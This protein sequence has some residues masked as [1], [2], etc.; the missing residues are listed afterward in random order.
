MSRIAK[1]IEEFCPDGVEFK[2]LG[3]LVIRNRGGGTPR[4]SISSYWDGDIPWASV[5]DLSIPG[6]FIQKTRAM[7]TTEGL[8]SSSSNVIPRGDVIV[9]VKISPGKMRIAATDIAINQDLRGLSLKRSINN[10]FLTY[11][12]ETL[13]IVGNGTIVKSITN[14]TLER[15]RVPVPPLEVQREIVKVLDAFTE[16][17]ETLEA[18]L[19]LR[20][21][22]YHYYREQLLTF[23]PP[24]TTQ[25][26]PNV[27]DVKMSQQS[28]HKKHLEFMTLR[29]LFVT[30]NGYTPSKSIAEYWTNG[31]IPWFRM[32]DI[33]RNGRI[34]DASIQYVSEEAVKGG[35]LIDANSII[36]AT[37][38][39][40]GEHA[41]ITV[42]YLSN[43][44]FTS[45]T[46]KS[47]FS[48][49]L[50]IKFLFYYCFLLADWCRD[51]TTT[52]SFASVNMNDFKNFPFPIP[53]LEEQRRIVT[54]LDK[55]DT[56][57]N[58]LSVGLPAEIGARR[59]QYEYYRNSLLTF[60]EAA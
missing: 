34:L 45:L 26:P 23:H 52:S 2:N 4:R 31:T 3:A 28:R 1:L 55:F 19:A 8:M 39:T 59:Q 11:Y 43:Q 5:G 9:A 24:S 14:S 38:A 57:V 12:F 33:R 10:S 32:D 44:R 22:Q 37:S 54:I 30:R 20:E 17:E 47:E 27:G 16:L 58:D 40:I 15:V 48:E 53:P 56:L 46:L 50:E 42:P 41:L 25:P 13:P 35:R 36:V 7:I 18:E 29:E 21:L 49:Q 60:E 6:K 51:N